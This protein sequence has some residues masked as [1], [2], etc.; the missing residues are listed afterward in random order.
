M[1]KK[2]LIIGTV[3][4]LG[5]AGY[6]LYNQNLTNNGASP[7]IEQAQNVEGEPIDP[8]AK[9][10]PE[11]EEDKT[12]SDDTPSTKESDENEQDTDNDTSDSAQISSAEQAANGNL[13]VK[14]KIFGITSGTCHLKVTKGSSSIT[15]S[16]EILY[17]PEH[18][19]CLGFEIEKS[20]FNESGQ[21]TV[22][23][24]VKGEGKELKAD[25]KKVNIQR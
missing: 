3:I 21:W 16:A 18:S 19:S 14:T 5:G 7:E 24:T 17:A 25:P 10:S 13:V 12:Q 4:L 9:K 1:L 22:N 11:N 6:Y 20:R 23:L 15:E 8:N 2:L